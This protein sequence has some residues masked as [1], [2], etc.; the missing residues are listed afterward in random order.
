MNTDDAATEVRG[1][2]VELLAGGEMLAVSRVP[3]DKLNQRASR[4]AALGAAGILD[5]MDFQFHLSRLLGEHERLSDDAILDTDEALFST[6]L[7]VASTGI[8]DTA[9][10]IAE[11]DAGD[12][13]YVDVPVMK[14]QSEVTYRAPVDGRWYVFASGDVGHHH[15]WVVSS[16][17]AIDIARLGAD[18]MSHKGDG[19]QFAD[20]V[21]FGLPV[22]AAADGVVVSARDDRP[23]DACTLRQPG[24]TFEDYEA[25]SAAHQQEIIMRDGFEG[26][27]GNYVLLRHANGEH[28]LYA[29]LRQGS[30]RVQPGQVVTAGTPIAEVGS[31]GN[32]TQ[33]HLHFQV[34]DGPDLSTARGLPVVFTGLREDWLGMNGRQLRAGDVLEHE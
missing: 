6:W 13:G 22:L 30:L 27:A 16:E 3:G 9:R 34:I 17:Y 10:V 20:Y 12:L 21:T 15:R 11:G 31:S 1:L 29:H 8:P 14:R 32:S 5:M 23:D 24:E 33:P 28:S 25:R 26:A 18:M 19:T 4:M 7:Y 2:R